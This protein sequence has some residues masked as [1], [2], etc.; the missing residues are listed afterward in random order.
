MNS[1]NRRKFIKIAGSSTLLAS[2]FPAVGFSALSGKVTFKPGGQDFSPNT[3]K[4]RQSIPSACWQCVSRDAISCFVEDGRLVKIEGN[5]KAIRNRGKICSKGQAGVNQVYDP[6]RVLYPFRRKPGTKRGAGQWE[7]ISWDEA[8]N[9][10]VGKL[11]PLLDKGEPEKFMFHYGRMKGSDSKIVKSCF[12]AAFGTGTIGNHTSI[13]ECAKWTAQELVWGK[14]YDTNDVE[15]SKIILNFGCNFLEAHTSHI[16]LSQR[17]ING[18]QNNGAE[19]YSFDVRLSNTAAKSKE[20]IPIKPGTDLAV[21]LAMS[22]VVMDEGLY[23]ADFINKWTNV[24][25]EQIKEFLNKNNYTP[26]WASK[27]STV[28][29]SKIRSLAIKFAKTKPGTIVSYR[30][31]VANYHGTNTER[32]VKMLDAICGNINIKGGTC[33]SVGAS[34][35]YPK[36]KHLPKAKKLKVIDGVGVALPTHHVS[37]QVLRMINE[38]PADKRP[39][40]YM[41]YCYE[42]VYANANMQENI[43]ILKN[44]SVIPYHVSVTPFYSESA[45]LADLILPDVTYLERW[46]WEDM[47]SYELIPEYYIRQPVVKPLGE[48]RQFQDVCIDLAKRLKS[49]DKPLDMGDFVSTEDFIKKSCEKTSKALK[50][51]LSFDQLVKDG[52]WVPD[53]AKPKY[54]AHAKK[55]DLKEHDSVILD[56]ATGVFWDWKK[57]KAKSAEEAKEKGYTKTKYSY[58]GYK[59]QKF[60]HGIFQGFKPDKVNKSGKFEINSILTKEKG[61][62][63]WPAWSDIPE[64]K[65]MGGNELILTTYKVAVQSHSRTQNSKWLTEIFHDNPAWLNS[66]TARRLGINNGDNIRITQVT[67]PSGKSNYTQPAKKYFTCKVHVTEAIH[68]NVVSISHH[69][70]HWEYGRIASG[71]QAAT[72]HVPG[73]D[74]KHKW[75]QETGYRAN[76]VMPNAPDPISGQL[77]F[78][79]TVVSVTKA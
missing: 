46:T 61:F 53:G 75:W 16:Q 23:N 67:K 58:K 30:G 62:D 63:S 74:A 11:Q 21:I 65:G 13:C 3:G 41:T 56:E 42:P 60:D 24:T 45:S 33:Q 22:K 40:V 2:L 5:P 79:D 10:L 26:E 37:H 20:W 71:K 14:H 64:H 8:L 78:M 1:L 38:A 19:L 36:P 6:D 18:I 15:N 70:G 34:W 51:K 4:E 31:A 76:W 27:I 25:P 66:K 43:D 55:L 44:E 7:R 47:A 68:P 50:Q 59:G 17:A 69:L 73:A 29:A 54:N 52:V 72:G 57:S 9:E 48:V 32:A 39:S 35:K 28:P 49:D 12:L 77:R